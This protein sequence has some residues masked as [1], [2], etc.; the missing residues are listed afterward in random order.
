MMGC[1]YL[2]KVL[3]SLL[4]KTPELDSL[5]GGLVR[6]ANG[7]NMYPPK[8][9]G[10]HHKPHKP[11]HTP[12]EYPHHITLLLDHIGAI[13]TTQCAHSTRS[14]ASNDIRV[15]SSEV[16]R[17]DEEHSHQ[18]DTHEDMWYGGGGE[19]GVEEMGGEV[20]AGQ[21]TVGTLQVCWEN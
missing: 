12:P 19:G 17:V 20:G 3:L 18:E 21:W 7:V 1:L 13:H 9:N 2:L 11:N 15:V 14:M 4:P 8:A 5:M 6:R 16:E 10:S